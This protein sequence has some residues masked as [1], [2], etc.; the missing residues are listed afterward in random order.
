MYLQNPERIGGFF[1]GVIRSEQK[2]FTAYISHIMLIFESLY[3]RKKLQVVFLL[4]PGNK[5]YKQKKR[6]MY[7]TAKQVSKP[8]KMKKDLYLRFN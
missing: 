3:I 8:F 4:A 1:L 5:I 6:K 7:K 2:I